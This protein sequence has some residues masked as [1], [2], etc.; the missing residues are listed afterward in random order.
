MNALVKNTGIIIFFL[1]LSSSSFLK[2]EVENNWPREIDSKEGTIIIYQPEVESLINDKMESR[3]AVSIITNDNTTPVFGAMWFNCRIST[4]RDERIVT[5]LDLKVI[6]SNFPDIEGEKVKKIESF[7][8]KEVPKWEM[9]MSLDEILA[10]MD[11]DDSDLSED[12]KLN[13]D[14]PEIIF[15]TAP[16]ALIYIDGEP[17]FKEIEKSNYEYVVN[18][19]FFIIKDTKAE[20]FYLRGGE[21]W[22]FSQNLNYNWKI[23]TD[24]PDKLIELSNE[25]FEEIDDSE[26]IFE[27]QDELSP[28]QVLV[29]TTP[30][31][32]LQSNGSP[33]YSSVK[34]TSLL[35]MTNTDDDI[36]MNINTQ[37][38][39][40]LISGRW[41]KSKSLD[42]NQWT[43]IPPDE[44]P[45]DFEKIPEDS[46]VG[47]VRANIYGTQESKEA[48]LET[49]IPQTAE[50]DRNSASVDVSYDGDAKFDPIEGTEMYYAVNTN[51]SVLLIDGRYY[52]CDNAV[53]FEG[54]S[55]VG[56]W[57]VS[58]EV[59]R[60]RIRQ[61]PPRYPVYNVR[62]VYIY[63]YSPTVVRVGYT[64]GYVHSYV[65]RGCV[66]YGTGYYYRPWYR[67]YYYPR[68]ITYGFRVHYNP[69]T[70]WGFTYGPAYRG[71]RWVR[72]HRHH[73][74]HYYNGYWGPTG[75]RHTYRHADHHGYK[76]GYKRG[77]YQGVRDSRAYTSSTG[78]RTTVS[79][80]V[81]VNRTTGVTR[82]G[83]TTYNPRTG[84]R[85]TVS[86]AATR[87]ARPSTRAN[88]VYSDRNGNVYRRTTS[89]NW[90][91]RS[92]G[93]WQSKSTTTRTTTRTTSSGNRQQNTTTRTQNRTTT[94][95]RKNP[96]TTQTT[97]R[98]T[99]QTPS[100]QNQQGRTLNNQY[101]SR[102]R[103]TQRT[104]NYNQNK[105]QYQHSGPSRSSSGSR[106]SEINK[107]GKSRT[108][109]R[110]S[111]SSTNRKPT[112]NNSRRR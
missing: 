93:N 98:A 78:R 49:Q 94:T 76:Q 72:Y 102:N 100:R 20:V 17:I 33:E 37:E 96:T 108:Q 3:S 110:S 15:K 103:S 12:E 35:Y 28:P 63:D 13:N 39:Y 91:Q 74:H 1:L 61:I 57:K 77:Y 75:Y 53:W 51:K 55:P 14:A 25:S 70:G 43:F 16:T 8:E 107:T 67:T 29:R 32:L 19:P 105:G 54:A 42:S 82:S 87:Q 60:E 21:F 5:L 95:T 80:N 58:V 111:S 45:E 30:T 22:Y 92:N 86:Q 7:I 104:Q 112:T 99:T 38:Y 52:C 31:E 44:V 27:N 47:N 6:A 50:I 81:Y 48:V 4:D 83:R 40:I 26:D 89:G 36:I 23:T 59:P 9:E 101:N 71:H 10:G 68:H 2:E 18:T 34:G 90:E 79:N 56:P 97:S 46:P 66:L 88:N 11:L 62:Y 41:Y 109:G 65:Y 73:H 69:Y 85:I 24:V 64:P 84:Q 106:S